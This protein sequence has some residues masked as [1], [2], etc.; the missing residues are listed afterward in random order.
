MF[1]ESD[2]ESPRA[3]SPWDTFIANTA[4]H[5]PNEISSILNDVPK[6]IPE[7]EY[8]RCSVVCSRTV[9]FILTRAMSNTS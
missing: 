6:L 3:G 9:I 7:V 4:T 5:S 8:A 2:S 1:G